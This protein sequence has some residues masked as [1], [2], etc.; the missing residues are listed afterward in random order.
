MMNKDE[1]K[2]RILSDNTAQGVL[3]HLRE[4]ESNRARMQ[5][6]WIWELLQNARDASSNDRTR[7]VAKVEL[8]KEE[9]VFQHNGRGFTEFEVGHL[10]FHG[11][12][13][14]EDEE[15]IG[16]YGSGF[17]TTH[18]LSPEI[19]VSGQLCDGTPFDFHLKRK[20]A[21]VKAL[22][23]S[24]DQAWDEFH[25]SLASSESMSDSF[26]TRFRYPIREDTTEL[27]EEGIETLRRDA[28]FVMVFNRQFQSIHIESPADSA[29]FEVIKR[30]TSQQQ[31]LQGI[32]VRTSGNGTPRTMYYLHAEHEQTSVAVPLNTTDGRMDCL[33]IG[34]TPKLFLGFPLIGTESFSSPAVINSFDF[35]P[36]ESRD[37]V[38]LGQNDNET[39]RRNQAAIKTAFE[40]HVEL[41]RFVSKHESLNI[42]NLIHILPFSKQNWLNVDWLREQLKKLIE[43]IRNV[44]AVLCGNEPTTPEDAILPFAE[45][46]VGVD[47]L[48]DLLNE[49]EGFRHKLP[50][51]DEAAGWHN[52]V[53][54]WAAVMGNDCVA[55]SYGESID[56]GKLVSHIEVETEDDNQDSP[57]GTLDR[58][59]SLLVED[60]CTVAWLNRLYTFLKNDGLDSLIRERC[61]VLGQVRSLDKLSNLY[62]DVD[63]DDELKHVADEL[64]G[65]NFKDSLR[66]KRLTA[67]TDEVGKGDYETKDLAQ[68]IVN[69]LQELSAKDVLNDDFAQASVRMLAWIVTKQEWNHLISFPAYSMRPDDGVR[70]LLRLGLQGSEDS[71]LPLAPVKAWPENLQEFADLF[72]RNYIL[73]DAFFD[74]MPQTDVWRLLDER[75][76]V[77]IEVL[78][79]SDRC[80]E[81]FLPDEPLPESD[82]DHRSVCAVATT[83]VVFLTKDRIGIMARVRDSQDRAR[84]FWRFLTEWLVER[85]SDDLKMRE[86][87]CEC[88]EIH[89][90]FRA[91]WLVPLVRNKWVPLGNDRRDRATAQSLAQLLRDSNWNP[92]SLSEASTTVRLL[93]AM[94]VTRLD[95]IREFVVS[96]DESRAILDDVMTNILVS[97][98]GDLSHVSEFVE[99][100]KS[101]ID[102]PA[103]LAERRKRREIVH[104]NQRLGEQVENLVK[105]GLEGE[106]FTVTRTGIG[107]DFEIEYD[108][109]EG[110]EEIGIE[111]SRNGRSWLIEVKAT[112]DQRVR[113]TTKQAATAVEKND[114]FLLCVVPVGID[115]IDLEEDD[116]FADMRFVQ[117]IGPR[118][119]P[120][121]QKL[122]SLNELRDGVISSSDSDIQ[123][124]FQ[125]GTARICV[126]GTVWQNGVCL[127]DLCAHL[128]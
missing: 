21:S 96:D 55:T 7:L 110:D 107:S 118:V 104:E 119:A 69:K 116:I 122:K 82:V 49:V 42:H 48:W 24:M 112:R 121:W 61:I 101:D 5:R 102:L 111:L 23:D 3:N 17:L 51:K 127:K 74:A 128:I 65:L 50:R 106:G 18:L 45:T 123:L 40:L 27:V 47:T 100:M 120:L 57:R 114:L 115:G 36:T 83:D 10:I 52:A 117:N 70:E 92:A 43:Q 26:T 20:V 125:A 79:N 103:H 76:Y 8:G 46:D 19:N 87:D 97:T 99:D 32:S 6:R 63:V 72:P 84:L 12:T 4:L 41:I 67:L 1:T 59:Q 113:M 126:D 58:L 78:I 62:R 54:S 14:L 105:K 35:T 66:D 94:K 98:D 34:N 2:N 81:D 37:G 15:T 86:V 16:Q 44:P 90:Y 39:N 124:E 22:A 56:G 108:F 88:G 33:P 60:V 89:R 71:E 28:P 109:I 29:K 53:K 75:G 30:V 9:L 64:L 95:L 38:Y 13:K 25:A 68:I 91:A 73:A 93:E 80:V 77:R 31:G 11:S 85:S